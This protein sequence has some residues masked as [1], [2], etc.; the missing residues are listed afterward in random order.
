LYEALDKHE[1]ECGYQPQQC[2]GCR[3]RIL[4]KDFDNHERSCASIEL[5]CQDCKLV[6]KRGEAA[7]KHTENICLKE[8][9]RQVREECKRNKSEMH[10]IT[11]QLYD[12]FALSK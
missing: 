11:V 9:L 1:I 12:L 7:T 3:S 5:T 4:K 8:Q 6:Y 10:A 2:P